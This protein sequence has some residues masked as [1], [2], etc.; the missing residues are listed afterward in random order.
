[1][2]PGEFGGFGIIEFEWMERYSDLDPLSSS[3]SFFGIFYLDGSG[4]GRKTPDFRP[5]M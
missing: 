1:L 5:G 3:H 4:E 2:N